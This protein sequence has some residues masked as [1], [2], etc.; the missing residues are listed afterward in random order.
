MLEDDRL[1]ASQ[2]L[3]GHR[4]VRATADLEV[5]IRL[6]DLEVPEEGGAH[7]L[8]VVLPGMDED[9]GVRRAQRAA[10]GSRLHELGA[11]PDD[12]QDPHASG[13]GGNGSPQRGQSPSKAPPSSRSWSGCPQTQTLPS[14]R[15][16]F[17]TT[18]S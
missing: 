10:D 9:L 3:A 6:W 13:A 2:H 17:P 4:P 8:V 16:G 14:R 7:R 5:D 11:R 12:A 1:E 15:A 18:S